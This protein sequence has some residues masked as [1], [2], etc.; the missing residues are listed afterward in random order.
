MEAEVQLLGRVTYEGFAAAWPS[1]EG[2]FADKINNGKKVVVSTTLTN[3]EWNNTIAIS[4][5]VPAQI[6]KLK[7][8]TDGTI[9]VAGSGTL[10]ATLLEHDLVDE[11][12]LMVFPT[13]LGRGKRLFPDGID[14]LKFSL[15]EAKTVGPDGVQV[16]TYQR[17]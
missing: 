8:E 12:R 7:E 10:V 17:T 14:R 9:L 1:R 6:A 4:E 5:D 15:V 16:Q 13:I 2:E 11:L 3:P